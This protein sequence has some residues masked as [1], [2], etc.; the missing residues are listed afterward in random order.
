MSM[1]EAWQ[2]CANMTNVIDE[3][4][5]YIKTVTQYQYQ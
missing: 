4:M 2:P 3:A 1:F 5:E